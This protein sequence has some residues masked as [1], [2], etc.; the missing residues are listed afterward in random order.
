[1]S[2][3]I[4]YE[5]SSLVLGRVEH[6]LDKE[7][8]EKRYNLSWLLKFLLSRKEIHVIITHYI[9]SFFFLSLSYFFLFFSFF[10][11]FS[12]LSPLFFLSSLNRINPSSPLLS[13]FSIFLLSLFP[14]SPVPI[15]PLLSSPL[16]RCLSHAYHANCC[17]HKGGTPVYKKG[18]NDLIIIY[19][20]K[21]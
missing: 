14:H 17:S 11:S 12:F 9:S 7:T 6:Q 2:N 18:F 21:K 16:S 20:F 8:G 3:Q 5:R 4:I 10:S 19:L 1:M 15:P 13:L